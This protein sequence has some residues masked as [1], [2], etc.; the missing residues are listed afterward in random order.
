MNV[1]SIVL[2]FYWCNFQLS[3]IAIFLL[4]ATYGFC[5]FLVFFIDVDLCIG[6]LSVIGKIL[7]WD[8]GPNPFQV[9]WCKGTY[10]FSA[11]AY[12]FVCK[13]MHIKVFE[14]CFLYL[15]TSLF[16]LWRF[17]GF[18]SVFACLL[19]FICHGVDAIPSLTYEVVY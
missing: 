12:A 17:L 6:S 14:V 3:C 5:L 7:S 11:H 18:N 2:L 1:I 4:Q 10:G 15:Q 9:D 8:W 16:W 19:F 13:Q